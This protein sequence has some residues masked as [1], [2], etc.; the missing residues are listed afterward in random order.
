MTQHSL[1]QVDRK[2]S[3]M[4]IGAQKA[5]TT[6]LKNYL[7]QHPSLETHPHKEFA[8]FFDPGQYDNDFENARKK[9][10]SNKSGAVQ[11]IAKNAGLYV[12][13]AGIAELKKHNSD[14]KL[15]LILRNPVERTYSSFLMEKNYGMIDSP[16]ESLKTV[17]QKKD[18]S[19]WRYEFLI[20]MSLYSRH[21]KM[22][23]NYFPLEQVKIVRYEDL[24]MNAGKLCSDIFKWTGV[25]E[26]FV[27]DTSKRFNET[28]VTRSLSYAKF[29]VRML[30]NHNPV[31]KMVRK[32][33]PGTMDYKVGELLRN[34]NKSNK[35]YK[36]VS[37]EMNNLL[38][39]F[40]LPFND[41]LS[42]LTGMDFSDWNEKK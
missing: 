33:L 1:P 8:F 39:D 11:L 5:G 12:K 18:R 9:Y 36:P 42:K 30:K 26:T 34:I 15:V 38:V 22:L 40:F 19:D 7:G 2:I 4:I 24:E 28:T 29:I 17:L 6:S 41:E 13:E 35:T 14:C 16:F 20:G 37:A 23:Y 27:S 21:L 32:I 3:L 31:K 10:F 25:G